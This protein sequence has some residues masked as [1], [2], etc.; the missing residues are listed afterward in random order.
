MI[1]VAS[2]LPPESLHAVTADVYQL[3]VS[4]ERI[5]IALARPC[6]DG[7]QLMDFMTGEFGRTV[8]TV[9]LLYS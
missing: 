4:P 9:S 3:A 5:L 7:N 8:S 6:M 2:E 1:Q